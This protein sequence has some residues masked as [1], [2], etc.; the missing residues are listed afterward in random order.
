M[1][2]NQVSNVITSKFLSLNLRDFMRGLIVAVLSAVTTTIY[3]MTQTDGGLRA[4]NWD[5]V[6]L[7]AVNSA[8]G[9]LITNLFTPTKIMVTSPSDTAV[10]KVQEGSEVKISVDGK[11]VATKEKEPGV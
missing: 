7:V 2:T 3:A 9:Y 8:L 1:A 11:T 6:I 4:I 10:K 5:T